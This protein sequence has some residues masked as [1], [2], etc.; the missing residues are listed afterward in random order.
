MKIHFLR[1]S[2]AFQLLD[3]DWHTVPLSLVGEQ[4]RGAG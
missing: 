1:R 2:H 3:I 4:I